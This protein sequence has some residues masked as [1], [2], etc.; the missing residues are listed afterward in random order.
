MSS[1]PF[2]RLDRLLRTLLPGLTVFLAVLLSVLPMGLPHL[3]VVMPFF[4][5]MAIYYWTVTRPDLLAAPLMFLIGLLQDGLAGTP[6]GLSAI[7]FLSA[8]YFVITQRRLL[9]G[10]SFGLNWFGFSV[11][12]VMAGAL[13]WLIACLFYLK[14][15]PVTPSAVQTVLTIVLYPPLAWTFAL[16]H[17]VLPRPV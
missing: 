12:A 5:L 8:H 6:L 14:L 3:P 4:T 9:A 10:Q 13:A 2:S 1:S 17:R 11:C 7:V 16:I 15:V